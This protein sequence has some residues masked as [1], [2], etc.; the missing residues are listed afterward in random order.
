MKK[1]EPKTFRNKTQTKILAYS[2]FI[3]YTIFFSFHTIVQCTQCSLTCAQHTHS[4]PL[5][6]KLIIKMK[7]LNRGENATDRPSNDKSFYVWERTKLNE[8]K[9]CMQENWKHLSK[10]KKNSKTK[11][12]QNWHRSADKTTNDTRDLMN[13]AYKLKLKQI[14][15]A[16]RRMCV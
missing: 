6:Y 8:R 1:H 2:I 14:K 11:H 15:L 7:W 12:V 13:I 10:E 9:A 16:S 4:L 3:I 5:Y